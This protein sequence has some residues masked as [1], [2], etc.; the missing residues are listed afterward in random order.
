MQKART[1]LTLG[2]WVT[3]LPYLGFPYAWKNTLFTL[4]GLVLMYFSYI[5]YKEFKMTE[6]GKKQTSFDNF[7]ENHNFKK[8]IN[9]TEDQNQN[10]EESQN[11]LNE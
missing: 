2:I 8:K 7:S 11:N 10:T 3:V 1:L 4:T 6:K 5:L 9:Q